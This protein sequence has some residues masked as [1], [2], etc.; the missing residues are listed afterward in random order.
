MTAILRAI[1]D[2]ET[3]APGNKE[4]KMIWTVAEQVRFMAALHAGSVVSPGVSALILEHLHPVQS[5]RWGLGT[6]GASAFKG[7][8]LTSE[9]ETRQMG[10]VDGFAVAIL[11]Y[12]VGPAEW[13]IDD[14]YAHVAQMNTLAAQL[15]Q[16]LRAQ[17][18]A[19]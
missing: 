5:Q 9:S 11:T 13:Q 19:R 14:D 7:G 3:V 8:W 15:Q 12:G 4:G 6:I 2:T 17:R 16:R 10:I 18:S 1:G